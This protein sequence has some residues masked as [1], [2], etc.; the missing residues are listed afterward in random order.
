MRAGD[1]LS[2]PRTLALPGMPRPATAA[3]DKKEDETDKRESRV[4][5]F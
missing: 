4:T 5:F 1:L 3:R 2:V